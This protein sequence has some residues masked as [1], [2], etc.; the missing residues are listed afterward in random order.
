MEKKELKRE[1]TCSF[2]QPWLHWS[3]AEALFLR[4]VRFSGGMKKL[5]VTVE[6]YVFVSAQMLHVF[7]T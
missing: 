5:Y 3:M 7:H 1:I 2:H 4:K 6:E